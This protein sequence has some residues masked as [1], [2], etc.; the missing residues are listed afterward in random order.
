ML[1][2]LGVVKFDLFLVGEGGGLESKG[3]M[4]DICYV[5]LKKL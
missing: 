2:P 3:E 1:L 4:R 5:V